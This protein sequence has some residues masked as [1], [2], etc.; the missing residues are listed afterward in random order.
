MHMDWAVIAWTRVT[1]GAL[2]MHLSAEDTSQGGSFAG[3]TTQPQP[4]HRNQTIAVALLVVSLVRQHREAF[5]RHPN[6]RLHF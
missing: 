1:I 6:V 2:K 4:N 3:R 5:T